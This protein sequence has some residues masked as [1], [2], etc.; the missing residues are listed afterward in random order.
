[1]SPGPRCRYT[2][3][4]ARI[5]GSEAEGTVLFRVLDESLAEWRLENDTVGEAEAWEYFRLDV[6]SSSVSPVPELGLGQVYTPQYRVAG[7]VYLGLKIGV[8]DATQLFQL[9]PDGAMSPGIEVRG[10]LRTIAAVRR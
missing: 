4:S 8:N 7:E 2:S 10:V 6:A 9:A 3:I 1:M 5:A